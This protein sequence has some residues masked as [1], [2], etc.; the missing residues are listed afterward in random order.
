MSG[1]TGR[2]DP[3]TGAELQDACWEMGAQ[4][5]WKLAHFRPCQTKHGWRTAVS[6]DGKGFP[7]LMLLHP[8]RQVL[9]F[10]EI[11]TKHEK[12]TPE[13]AEWGAWL[14]AAGQDWGV[15]R[16]EQWPS[17]VATLSFGRAVIS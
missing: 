11:K 7:D 5:G 15:W 12:L 16:P 4:F 13:Q 14:M 17:I 6:Y 1:V 3:M 10:R 9:M 8:E 2:P